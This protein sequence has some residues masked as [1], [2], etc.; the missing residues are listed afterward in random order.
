MST[1]TRP[2]VR[3]NVARP[4][5]AAP[6]PQPKRMTLAA[7]HEGPRKVPDRVVMMGTPGIGKSTWAASAPNAIFIPTEEGTHH[8][9]VAAF[10]VAATFRDV[11]DA[12]EVLRTEKHSYEHVVLDTAD[13]LETLVH[14]A[15]CERNG[16][17]HIEQPDFQKG[18][19]AAL[20]DWRTL[21]TSL[22]RLQT[23]RGMGVI[24]VSHVQIRTFRN[25]SG[26]DY[27]RY[28][29]KIHKKAAA[30]LSEWAFAVL[31]AMQVEWVDKVKGAQKHKGTTDGRRIVKTTRTPAWDAKNRWN[32]PDEIP[33]DY[34]EYATL[35]DS[36]LTAA[37]D[38]LRATAEA[39]ITQWNP[40]ASKA[41]TARKHVEECGG[42]ARKLARVVEVLKARVAE[43]A[44][45]QS[46]EAAPAAGSN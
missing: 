24:L 45:A 16:W 35:R 42:D 5:Q 2:P 18:F 4:A 40:E 32:L 27:D 31:F 22:E 46:E 44:E 15:T 26:P 41:A 11:L 7:I 20:I 37:A 33:L 43:S 6:T 1:T 38:G 21:L 39:L 3:P 12:C 29:P 10:P 36:A 34:A 14:R 13:A 30:L 19:E 9:D 23:E 8:L 17:S 28:E 25:P